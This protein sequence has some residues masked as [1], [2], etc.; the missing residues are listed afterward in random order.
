MDQSPMVANNSIGQKKL[1]I[2]TPRNS[3]QQATPRR[4]DTSLDGNN[5]SHSNKQGLDYF[6]IYNDGQN[7]GG[8]PGS[9]GAAGNSLGGNQSQT[10]SAFMPPSVPYNKSSVAGGGGPTHMATVPGAGNIYGNTVTTIIKTGSMGG[11]PLY[12]KAQGSQQTVTS[13]ERPQ[14]QRVSVPQCASDVSANAFYFN[15]PG[16]HWGIP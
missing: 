4:T 8:R 12:V 3:Q 15:S 2:I 7:G 16:L 6:Y 5:P 11:Q 10:I 14:R 1:T 9:R 13:Q